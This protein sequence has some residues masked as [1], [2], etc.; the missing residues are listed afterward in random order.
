MPEDQ[1]RYRLELDMRYGDQRV[2][3]S[4]ITEMSRL[5]AQKD[6]LALMDQFHQSYGARFGEGSQSPEAGVRIN[7]I[8]VC[9]YVEQPKVQFAK[10]KLNGKRSEERRVGQEGVSTCRSRLSPY[11]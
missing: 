11:H 9:S 1:I 10:L 8:R 2:Q 4:V 6:V 5:K 7:T 3:T